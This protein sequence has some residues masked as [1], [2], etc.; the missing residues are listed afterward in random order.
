MLLL[1]IIL[2]IL[3]L[4]SILK[5]I[6]F[7][8]NCY[9]TKILKATRSLIYCLILILISTSTVF[10][11][12]NFNTYLSLSKTQKIA[13]ISFIRISPQ[14]YQAHLQIKN[15]I[16]KYYFLY[17]DQW[18]LSTKILK[19]NNIV[20]SFLD[21]HNL[22]HLYRLSGHYN[23]IDQER[24]NLRSIFAVQDNNKLDAWKLIRKFPKLTNWLID[25][26]YGNAVFMPMGNQF[27]YDIV[28]GNDG[29]IAYKV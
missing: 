26:Y 24:N 25:A 22:Y 19:W 29:L 11:I 9:Y 8:K 17:G 21:F 1:D 5:F 4:L 6:D 7:I 12:L 15:G 10:I 20:K 28:L 3:I 27:K 18:M 14:K 23:N 16:P 2:L 13:T